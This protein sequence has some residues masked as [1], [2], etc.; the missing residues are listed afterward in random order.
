MQMFTNL[1]INTIKLKELI[2]FFFLQG[3]TMKITPKILNP[4]II[5]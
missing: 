1:K 5:K 3:K 4:I 2:F